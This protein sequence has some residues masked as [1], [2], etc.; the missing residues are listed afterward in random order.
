MERPWIR[1]G[2]DNAWVELAHSAGD[3]WRV[4]A[5]WC[6]SLR[7]DF[8]ACLTM[9]E[10]SDFAATMLSHLNMASS[11]RFSVAVTPGRNNPLTLRAEPVGEAFAFFARLTP[12]GD[13]EVCHMQM[14]I[15]PIDATELRGMF[16]RLHASA[17]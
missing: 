1:L 17:L 2:G 4:T 11:N 15:N 3:D 6:S 12:N 9:A 10:V 14:D 13:D 7:A 5:D 8:T 16:E